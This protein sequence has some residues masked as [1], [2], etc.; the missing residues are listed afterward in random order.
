[1]KYIIAFL[2]LGFSL[3]AYSQEWN[4]KPFKIE[5]E[6]KSL[7]CFLKADTMT[8]DEVRAFFEFTDQILPKRD[9]IYDRYLYIN[10]AV[11]YRPGLGFMRSPH[12][13]VKTTE[14]YKK[15]KKASFLKGGSQS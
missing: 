4:G 1:M 12:I 9:Q 2:I 6:N 8:L 10:G 15:V 14:G 5:T 11:Y 7:H 13:Y 3:S